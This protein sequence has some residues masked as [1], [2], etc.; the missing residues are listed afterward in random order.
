MKSPYVW[1]MSCLGRNPQCIN[2]W[3]SPFCV[4]WRCRKLVKCSIIVV[5]LPA[6]LKEKIIGTGNGVDSKAKNRHMGMNK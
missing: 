3:L 6:Q 2:R 1:A 5:V 4:C